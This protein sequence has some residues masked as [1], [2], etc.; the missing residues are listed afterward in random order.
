[1]PHLLHDIPPHVSLSK[2]QHMANEGHEA[3]EPNPETASR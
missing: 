3:T 1:L 2:A